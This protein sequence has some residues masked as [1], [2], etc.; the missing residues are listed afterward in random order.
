MQIGIYSFNTNTCFCGQLKTL[1]EGKPF[2][3]T[4]ASINSNS[5]MTRDNYNIYYIYYI[6]YIIYIYII[7]WLGEMRD[8]VAAA[9]F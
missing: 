8:Q 2:A 1:H 4:A 7:S 5:K 3:A 9:Q 6:I